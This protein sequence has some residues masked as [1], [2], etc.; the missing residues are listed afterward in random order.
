MKKNVV[1]GT[2]VLI[3]AVL[4][5]LFM[6]QFYHRYIVLETVSPTGSYR[7]VVSGDGV[8]ARIWRGK[9]IL[10]FNI[11]QDERLILT[12]GILTQSEWL[13][14]S[15]YRS[16]ATYSWEG[17]TVLRFSKN[18]EAVE[19]QDHITVIN[20]TK[21]TIKYL[22]IEAGDILLVMDVEPD[23]VAN[24][25]VPRQKWQSWVNGEGRFEDGEMIPFAGADFPHQDKI[26]HSLTICFRI[27]DGNLDLASPDLEG[28]TYLTPRIPRSSC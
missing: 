7:V 23:T 12:D 19:M 17:E 28:L 27:R 21:K 11:A 9:K 18:L 5:L 25:S 13:D 2:F 6:W 20:S 14:D 3:L 24:F 26:R 22:K 8:L 4:C 15:A 1:I 16:V 10:R